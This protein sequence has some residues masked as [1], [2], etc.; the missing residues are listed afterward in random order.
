LR[1]KRQQQVVR[2]FVVGDDHVDGM[3][4]QHWWEVHGRIHF[5]S[6]E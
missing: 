6:F 3:A 5:E 1:G 2:G 4:G